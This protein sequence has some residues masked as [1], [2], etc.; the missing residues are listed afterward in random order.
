MNFAELV[1]AAR[2]E[3][4]SPTPPAPWPLPSIAEVQE[5]IGPALH[6]RQHLLPVPEDLLLQLG[7]FS[8]AVDRA[9]ALPLVDHMLVFLRDERHLLLPH[10]TAEQAL[11]TVVGWLVDDLDMM[12]ELPAGTLP[13]FAAMVR[14]GRVKGLPLPATMT[15][16]AE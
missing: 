14:H 2:V 6:Q 3:I 8:L 12:A 10:T 15:A 7:R 13:L 16:L 1:D 5:A 9:W 11:L 4:A